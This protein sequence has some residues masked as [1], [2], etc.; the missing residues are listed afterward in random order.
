VAHLLD[1]D[2]EHP[3]LA[4]QLRVA[5]FRGK[6]DLNVAFVAGDGADQLLGKAGEQTLG[7]ELDLAGFVTR[8]ISLDEIN[9]GFDAMAA[10]TVALAPKLEQISADQVAAPMLAARS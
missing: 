4:G 8:T 5:V 6:G 10:A 9:K 2:L 7:A 3:F 1:G